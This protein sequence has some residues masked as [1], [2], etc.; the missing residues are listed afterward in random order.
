MLEEGAGPGL[1]L[2][3]FAD[4]PWAEQAALSHAHGRVVDLGCGAGRLALHLQ[5]LGFDV[6]GADVSPLAVAVARRRGLRQARLATWQEL[7][8]EIASFDTVALFG[9][10]AGIFGTPARCRAVLGRWARHMPAGATVLAESTSPYGGAAPLLDAAHR[11]ANRRAGRMPG[12][13][14][15]RYRYGNRASPWFSWL[16]LSPAELRRLVGGTGWRVETV[17]DEGP[18]RPFV[19]VLRNTAGSVGR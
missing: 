5:G 2:S 15:L 14:R 9:N 7:S 18:A 8:G 3:P 12:Q 17:L 11:R 13:L 6:V 16:F 19:A 1:Y 4:W 10:N